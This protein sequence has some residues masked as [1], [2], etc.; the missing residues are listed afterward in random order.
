LDEE[1]AEQ[2]GVVPTGE[3]PFYIEPPWLP[4]H[5]AWV[6]VVDRLDVA[7]VPLDGA[8]VLVMDG[9]AQAVG[10]GGLLGADFFRRFVVG[11]DGSAS[12][13][14]IMPH[15]RFD[16]PPDAVALTAR[17]M[18]RRIA[19]RGEVLNVDRGDLILDTG[20][21]LSVVVTSPRMA[22]VHPRR[23]GN[24]RYGQFSD[25][26]ISPDYQAMVD[27]LR[28]GPFQFAA[29]PALGRD[30]ERERI[31]AGLGLVGMGTMRHFRMWFDFRN[32]VVYAA[33]SQSYYAL[34]R[35]GLEFGP[36]DDDRGARVA[37]V[38]PDGPGWTHGIRVGDVILGVEGVPV[39]G[40]A[41]AAN[42]LATHSR[43][44]VRL[45]VQRRDAAR[46]MTVTLGPRPVT[47][48]PLYTRRRRASLA[49][50]CPEGG[51]AHPAR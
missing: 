25:G 28:V 11:V 13:I 18:S 41:D 2:I 31:S 51:E 14:S 47:V 1:L 20:A 26:V 21:S 40:P 50:L 30:R 17:G 43:G 39:P 16:Q 12:T 6:G 19:I 7:G 33:P 3:V 9:L 46:T 48:D 24:S 36:S 23:R 37:R 34:A 29:L 32:R 27:G 15:E 45:I 38:V 42:R 44:R 35:I 5:T 49:P 22:A 8:R 4:A 10:S